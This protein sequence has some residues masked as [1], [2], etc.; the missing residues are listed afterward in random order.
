MSIPLEDTA[1]R[2]LH[3]WVPAISTSAEPDP[4]IRVIAH[5]TS[6]HVVALVVASWT[7]APRC[8]PEHSRGLRRPVRLRAGEVRAGEEVHAGCAG[9]DE[10]KPADVS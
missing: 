1:A 10:L 3:A 2:D 4:K 9:L 7:L 8:P 6:A 5:P